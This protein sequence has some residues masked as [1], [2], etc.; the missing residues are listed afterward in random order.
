MYRAIAT[1]V[2]LMSLGACAPPPSTPPSSAPLQQSKKAPPT[3]GKRDNTVQK[4]PDDS[5]AWI[6]RG[7]AL[8]NAGDV[9]G[10]L[11]S[12]NEAIRLDPNGTDLFSNG[13]AFYGRA[14]CW[15]EKKNW[16]MAIPDLDAIIRINPNHE[17]GSSYQLRGMARLHRG[18]FDGSIRDCSDAL[19]LN[20]KN[21]VGLY[22][23]GQ[24]FVGKKD[25]DA[26]IRDFQGAIALAPQAKGPLESLCGV[27]TSKGDYDKATIAFEN[28]LRIYP[29]SI[30]MLIGLAR[31]MATCPDA[32]YRNGTTSVELATKALK[33]SGDQNP[34]AMDALAAAYAEIGAFDRAIDCQKQ[35]LA[36]PRFGERNPGAIDRLTRYQ[37]GQTYRSN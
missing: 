4:S 8:L 37:N 10:A 18:D 36:V 25:F 13:I 17:G 6:A 22:F 11:A 14:L 3:A 32:K 2:L 34:H 27:F 5:S 26:A 21:V 33:L 16:D 31:L 35:A 28:G 12:F 19:R 15:I 30:S 9:E 7:G 1:A 29:E 20:P 23:R 24:A